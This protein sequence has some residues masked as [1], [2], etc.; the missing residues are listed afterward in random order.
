MSD[1]DPVVR[2]KKRETGQGWSS[3]LSCLFSIVVVLPL[4]IGVLLPLGILSSVKSLFWKSK[5]WPQTCN[6][7][8][9][10]AP[11]VV[12]PKIPDVNS[13]DIKP[14]EERT[15]DIVLYGATGFTGK[16]VAK[17]LA[18]N[19]PKL[20]WAIAGRRKPALV[21]FTFVPSS[22]APFSFSEGINQN[23]VGSH[24]P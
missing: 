21:H 17:Y 7:S 20:R 5:G 23:I 16:L 15:Y 8:P 4:S 19:Y 18:T 14:K 3:L 1:V 10:P 11:T 12:A 22:L 6:C 13:D 2:D 24:R 9:P